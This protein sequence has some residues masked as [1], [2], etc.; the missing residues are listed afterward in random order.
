M[1]RTPI[2]INSFFIEMIIVIVF[3]T[4]SV[5]VTLHLFVAANSRA[6]QSRDLNVA[7]IKAENIAE[8]VKALASP[9]ALPPSLEAAAKSSLSGG[10]RYRIGYDKQWNVT[11]DDPYY[12]ADVILEK[13]KSK[14]GTMV[15]ADI[16]INRIK[17]GAKKD[18]YQLSTAKYL[19]G[20]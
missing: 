2:R 19:P 20:S 12:T 7:V 14:S 18:I 5:S 11:K 3:F 10:V 17:T 6:Q 1:K 15:T 8:Q 9:E 16:A 4:I 13:T